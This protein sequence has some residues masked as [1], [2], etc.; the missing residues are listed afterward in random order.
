MESRE[1]SIGRLK[2]ETFDVLILGGGINGA[3]VAAAL[4]ASGMKTALIDK[5]DFANGTSSQTSNLAWGGI[6]YLETGEIGLVRSLCKSRNHLM[7]VFPSTVR[8]IR[9]LTSVPKKFRFPAVFVYFGALF[10]WALGGFTTAVPRYIAASALSKIEPVVNADKVSAAFEYSDAY[11]SDN[12]ARFVFNFILSSLSRGAA[13]A[14]YVESL[15][16]RRRGD[17]WH[18]KVRDRISSQ[19]FS[20]QARV[21]INACGPYADQQ[22]RLAEQVTD[23]RHIFSKG[24]HLVVDQVTKTNR[25]L[26]FFASDGR[27][28]FVIPMGKRSCVGTTD[29]PVERPTSVVTAEDRRFVLDNV[30]SALLLENPL[31]TDDIVAERCGVRPL[32]VNRHTKTNDWLKLSRK[33]A[34][35]VDRERQHIAIFGGKFTDCLNVGEEITDIV[36]SMTNGGERS[37]NRWY[38]EPDNSVRQVFFDRACDMNLDAIVPTKSVEP[39]SVRFWRRYGERAHEILDAVV[40]DRSS[41]SPVSEGL[42]VARCELDYAAVHEMVTKLEDFVRRRSDIALIETNDHLYATGALQAI[43]CRLFGNSAEEKLQEYLAEHVRNE[44][45]PCFVSGYN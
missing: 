10:Y 18:V 38:G 33:H 16:P 15:A 32:A 43:A 8:E 5:G 3:T 45:E 30:N 40:K 19:E 26:T 42:A 39:L 12:D 44:D 24:I 2:Q 41:A 27:P 37:R 29:T 7:D 35:D 28:F 13:I 23:H 17:M 20:I 25:I 9:F 34:I 6:K 1:K 14:N 11:F 4:S 31:T 21:L 22:N 36:V